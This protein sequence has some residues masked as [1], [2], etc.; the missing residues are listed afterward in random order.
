MTFTD[1]TL[2]N[3]RR[4]YSS[5]GKPLGSERVN[6]M[7]SSLAC[8]RRYNQG[9]R[10][11]HQQRGLFITNHPDAHNH[12]ISALWQAWMAVSTLLGLMNMDKVG[13]TLPRPKEAIHGCQTAVLIWYRCAHAYA[14]WWPDQG[15][16]SRVSTLLSAFFFGKRAWNITKLLQIAKEGNQ[17]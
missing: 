11:G 2:F 9:K 15:M 3:A 16:V 12:I 10:T 8:K 7:Q 14:L 4:F 6:W 17:A 5:M 13:E 1:F